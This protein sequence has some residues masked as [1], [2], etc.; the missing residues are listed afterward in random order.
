MAIGKKVK[1]K[2]NSTIEAVRQV[3][4]NPQTAKN[5]EGI[6]NQRYSYRVSAENKLSNE[7]KRN[8]SDKK[9]KRVP[10]VSAKQYSDTK[11]ADN[12][13]KSFSGSA[14]KVR[15]SYRNAVRSKTDRS[16]Y[17]SPEKIASEASHS[18]RADILN[19]ALT[20]D[21]YGKRKQD[22]K[23]VNTEKS[24]AHNMKRKTI[25]DVS[26]FDLQM[27]DWG[28]A[29]ARHEST[30]GADMRWVGREEKWNSEKKRKKRKG[31]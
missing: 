29:G 10:A 13:Q 24:T 17:R 12:K 26:D 6:S 28:R 4:Q 20:G 8:L 19:R 31:R 23:N 30:M 7:Q 22:F 21:S 9:I 16:T 14:M 27:G 3:A 11:P 25:R 18:T 1:K 2:S 15:A 5:V